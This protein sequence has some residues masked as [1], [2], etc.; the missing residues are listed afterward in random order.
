MIKLK[1][2]KINL[3]FYLAVLV[4]A[5]FIEASNADQLT[6]TSQRIQDF[7]QSQSNLAHDEELHVQ[8]LQSDSNFKGLS[9]QD[10]IQLSFAK[11][12]VPTHNN[13]IQMSCPSSPQ[14]NVYV[15]IRIEVL[16]PVLS[17][18]HYMA[19][20]TTIREEDLVYSKQ[21][22][23]R[24][25]EGYYLNPDEIVG[26][27]TLH[28]ISSGSAFTP[29]NVKQRVLVHRNH[30]IKLLLNQG[31]VKVSMMGIAKS[32]GSMNETIKVMNPSSKKVVYAAVTGMNQVEITT[33]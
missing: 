4:Q 9:C 31:G 1:I 21:D 10:K 11:N 3:I 12:G 20:G 8:V 2:S 32:N 26:L 14:W 18:S 25:P 33:N 30:T 15:P 27:S 23:K 16:K 22:K 17:A 6:N 28:A 5:F 29:K 24:L 7:V 13:T 19:S